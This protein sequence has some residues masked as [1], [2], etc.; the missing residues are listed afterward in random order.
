[1]LAACLTAS[2]LL[3]ASAAPHPN[4]IS[5]SRVRV[6]PQ[7]DRVLV[8]LVCEA[9][10]LC[11]AV[12][13]DRDGDHRLDPAELEAGWDLVRDYVAAHY[14]VRWCDEHE[15][16]P[17]PLTG[18]LVSLAES[19][20][21]ARPGSSDAQWIELELEYPSARA[22]EGLRIQFRLFYET[23][24]A[25][26]DFCEVAW[27]GEP[28]I[29]WKFNAENDESS[30]YDARLAAEL[31]LEA[32]PNML[33]QSLLAG[34]H[35]IVTG[36]DH[37]CFLLALL[38]AARGVRSLLWTITA[39]TLAHSIT[40]ALAALD[41]LRVPG[42]WVEPAIALSIAYVAAMN[43]WWR[44][45][46]APWSEALGFGLIHGL[47]FAGLLSEMLLDEPQKLRVLVG[48]NLG[49]ELGQLA[50]V[51]A[52]LLHFEVIRRATAQ[53][54]APGAKFAPASIERSISWCV[55]LAGL[56]WFVER[57]FF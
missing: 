18:S 5:S 2:W 20:A 23:N 49:V 36:W 16:A 34:A 37:L 32:R 45:V 26:M 13:I 38:V 1:M 52:M 4:S 40:L 3:V 29:P 33:G 46:R 51:A 50:F 12:P 43:L 14:A 48:F 15:T 42:S 6:P 28:P 22:I 57:V 41:V 25:H 44:R 30:F 27:E 10:T 55:L 9:P 11:E 54:R 8:E 19:N 21:D 39:F 47:G 24:P 35:H 53:P 31:D 56:Y 7:R 17:T